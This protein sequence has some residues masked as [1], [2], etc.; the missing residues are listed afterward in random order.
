MKMIKSFDKF[1]YKI[2][3]GKLVNLIILFVKGPVRVR[4]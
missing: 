3:L 1:L 4:K 2:E